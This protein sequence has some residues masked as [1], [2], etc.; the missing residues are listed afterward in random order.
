MTSNSI[1]RGMPAYVEPQCLF[2]QEYQRDKR[3]DVYSAGVIL[4]E[5][6]S[7]K[8]PFQNYTNEM[9]VVN[10]YQHKREKHVEGTPFQYT[11]LYKQCWDNDP[12]NRPET[13]LI[14]DTIKQLIHNETL[15]QHDPIETL[16]ENSKAFQDNINTLVNSPE[17]TTSSPLYLP[18]IISS[19]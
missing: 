10:I 3:S 15:N 14:L 9:I 4:W 6:S 7:G 16:S 11:E 12:A 17:I 1:V 19:N 2:N 5:I 8:P 18:E 13:K